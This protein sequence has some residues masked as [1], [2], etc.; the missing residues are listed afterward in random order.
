MLKIISS[1]ISIICISLIVSY[2]ISDVYENR[3][4]FILILSI[5]VVHGANDLL[6]IKK[7]SKKE[8]KRSEAL[9]FFYYLTIVF[10]GFVFFYVF[11][12]IALL[13]FVI[14]SI[15]HF[16]EQ[17][18]EVNL[19]KSDYVNLNKIFLFIFHGIIF[20][21]IIFMNNLKIVNEVLSSFNINPLENYYLVL[22]L[23]VFSILYFLFLLYLKNLR[24]YLFSEG[25]FFSLLFL[26]TINTTLIFGF[27]IYFIFFH[28]LL[29]IKDQ[30]KFIYD[31]DNPK[32]LKKYIITSMPYF[33]LA[34]TFLLIF[35]IVVDLETINLLPIIFT[36][37]AAITFPHV[38]VIEKMYRHLK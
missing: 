13:T 6:I 16:G 30:I 8:P 35:Y 17:H 24:K 26:L 9:Y 14:V 7:Y 25:I 3:L 28:S 4:G 32:N 22:A 21:T 18:W 31:D 33:I 1:R 23:I 38:L 5:G 27:A 2:F 37:L 11:P 19:S 34:L 15:Y 36:F 10:L 12:S 20:F 29:S